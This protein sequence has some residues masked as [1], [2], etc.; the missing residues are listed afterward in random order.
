MNSVRVILRNGAR[1]VILMRSENTKPFVFCGRIGDDPAPE[2]WTETGRW[3]SE[4]VDH[5]LDI[6]DF[7]TPSGATLK[8]PQ[9]VS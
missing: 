3:F 9:P 4:S 5:P 2:L 6:S 1:G 7:L 8:M